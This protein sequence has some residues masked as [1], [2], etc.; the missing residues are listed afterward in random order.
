LTKEECL[1]AEDMGNFFRVPADNRDLNYE[2]YY[3]TGVVEP[4]KIEEFRSDN[5]KLLNVEEVKEKLL[6]LDYIQ[7]ELEAR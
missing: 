6:K 7:R 5:T 3:E 2:K 1:H 4:A